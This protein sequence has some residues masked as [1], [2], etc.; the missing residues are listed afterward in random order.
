MSPAISIILPTYNG[1]RYIRQSIESCLQQTFTDFELI[2][3]N[4]CSTDNTLSIIN[5]YAAKDKRIKILNNPFN[6]KLPQSL[7]AGFEVARGA[8]FTWTSDDNYYAPNALEKMYAAFQNE[9]NIDLVYA[10]YTL[11]NDK[12]V[13]T[14]T[15]TFGD[16]NKSFS[17]W[18]GCGACFLYKREVHFKNGGYNPAAFLI[19]D[20]DFFVRAYTHA[21]FYYLPL[22]NLYFYREHGASLTA[23]QSAV[24]NDISK[25]FLE[26]NLPLLEKKLQTH[27]TA[28]LYRK[29]AV[30]YA[31][32]KN[33]TGI[34]KK[35]LQQLFATSKKQVL[36][37]VFYVLLK[38][39]ANSITVGLS[40]LFYFICFFF[41]SSKM[42]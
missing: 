20:Y 30:H 13:V 41:R 3:V 15:R 11:I 1:A 6:K 31:V 26:R 2:I 38:K 9:P 4:D 7:N 27:E 25:I 35:Y 5:E 36:V 28:L 24:I 19:E 37:T 10:D 23:T 42:K 18:L 8:Y 34:Y 17:Q 12:D 14:G 29:L 16:I 40:G 32:T 22:T 21:Q 39:I 33:N